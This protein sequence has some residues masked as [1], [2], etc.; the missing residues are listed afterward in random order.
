MEKIMK[1]FLS[2]A[3]LLILTVTLLLTGCRGQKQIQSIEI[4]EGLKT[5]Y[6]IGDT[7]DFS[8]V[9]AIV[10]YNDG[11]TENVEASQLTF[12]TI[13]TSTAG[14]KSLTVS[15]KDFSTSYEVVVNDKAIGTNRTVESIQYL[16]GINT[17]VFQ[18]DII[19]FDK[20]VILVKYNNGTEE[21][22]EV[23]TNANIKHNGGNIDTSELGTQ[24]L[25]ITYMGKKTELE[26]TVQEILLT[27]IEIDGDSVDTVITEGTEFVYDN[28]IVYANYN[29]GAR[30]KVDL[31]DLTVEQNGTLVTVTY[32][33]QTA[34]LTLS[35][36][37]P[38]AV[39][40]VIKTTGYEAENGKL[41]FG[42]K[43]DTSGVT[44]TA[45]LNNGTTKTIEN[46]K[47][48]FSSLEV[49]EAGE[50]K[51]TAKYLDDESITAEYTLTVLSIK[52]IT[53]NT[54]SVKVEHPVGEAFD[55]SALSVLLTLSD[56]SVVT[57]SVL[58]GVTVDL[59]HLDVEVISNEDYYITASYGGVVSEKLTIAVIDPN[60]NYYIFGVDMPASLSGLDSKKELFLNKEYG[61]VVGDDNPFIFKLSLT[62]LD[63]NDNYVEGFSSYVSYFEIVLNS[64]TLEGDE[65]DKY[66]VINAE[67]NS[68]DFTE[69]AIGKTFTI[70][71]RPLH[72]VDGNEAEMT[73]SLD[74]TV[75]DG[76][77]IYEAWELN[78][79]TNANETNIGDWLTGETRTQPQIVDD[80]LK[81]KGAV[82]PENLAGLVIHNDLIIKTTDIPAEYFVGA[83]RNNELWDYLTIFHHVNDSPTKTFSLYGNYYTVFS[84]NLP[85]VCAPGTGNQGDT[86]SNG[87]L[88][89]FT[90]PA[91]DGNYD[92]T[93]YK[94]NI[95]S[96][97]MRDDNPNTDNV[98]TADRDM[99]GLIGMKVIYQ[100]ANLENVRMEAFYISF[101]IDGDF[102]TANL[103]EC[104]LYNSWQNHI[105][106]WA[107]N[108][109]QSEDEYPRENYPA[110]TLNVTNSSITKCGGPVIISQTAHTGENRT[111]KCGGVVNIDAA[112]EIWTFVT[113]EEAW[114]KAMGVT[115]TAQQIKQLG[116]VLQGVLGT[117]FITQEDEN[118][119]TSGGTVYMNIV[120]IQLAQGETV[121]EMMNGTDDLDGSFTKGGITYM[122]MSDKYTAPHAGTGKPIGY[123][124]QFVAQAVASTRGQAPVFNT[125]AGGVGIFNGETLQTALTGDPT[126]DAMNKEVLK[127]GDFIAMHQNNMG[128]VLGY[129]Y[130]VAMPAVQ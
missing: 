24:T 51:I 109:V 46:A 123:G 70:K 122:D 17:N 16:S 78:Y 97:Y 93:Q 29:N 7:P 12:G 31:K 65:L 68:I 33:N 114:F 89:R 20:I 54:N 88:F 37:P 106:I 77:N 130:T 30:L 34:E 9:K 52:K 128:F 83:N 90:A 47:L 95:N 14:K 58:D 55:A 67:K 43:I 19:N 103:N 71:T 116:Y 74:V 120:M 72:G 112:T 127:M 60:I 85:N 44:A 5:E 129:G 18:N 27:G 59:S 104:K 1:K 38:V 10:T 81:T 3:L 40:M 39:S 76:Y 42:D 32:K 79:L 56:D 73:R 13:D 86:V 121:A 21:T 110:A 35:T 113:G 36:T 6:T 25:T 101:F 118:G 105:F 125:C 2:L 28:M 84:Y 124:N 75:V 96:L 87:Q 49:T 53:I 92:H 98:M 82:R 23:A 91:T 119:N 80:F 102:T 41:V 62:I 22:Q 61:Y 8:G 63:E 26:I 107:T 100:E 57:R 66:V 45:T 69:E 11:S 115:G 108:I 99:R 4:T 48:S 111:D 64:V 50:F 126:M 94:L 117:T 15:Y